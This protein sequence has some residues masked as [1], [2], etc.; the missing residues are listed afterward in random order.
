MESEK[1]IKSLPSYKWREDPVEPPKH[2]RCVRRDRFLRQHGIFLALAAAFTI[3]TIL[4][5]SFVYNRAL[6]SAEAEYEE[7]FK[8]WKQEY[9]AQNFLLTGK[10]SRDAAIERDAITA[11]HDGGVWTTKEAFQTYVWNTAVREKRADYPNNITDVLQQTGQYAFHNPYG[12]YN[13]EKVEW[14]REVYEQ[15][16]DGKL[17]TGLTLE[18]Q[19]L[20]MR[21]NGSVCVLHTSYDFYTNNDDP[22]RCS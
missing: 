10:A 4:L 13:D 11:A 19:F 18:H 3:Y 14:A 5:S 6:K 1:T 16:Y 8:T 2:A 17:P 7:Q 20:E 22:W 21:N 15:A 12:V 9:V